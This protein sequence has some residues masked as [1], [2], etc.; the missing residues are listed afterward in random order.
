MLHAGE[1]AVVEAEAAEV[2]EIAGGAIEKTHDHALAV[3]GGDGGD[4]EVDFAAQDF[5]FDASVLR[6]TAFGDIELGHQ[7]EARDDGG[8]HFARRHVLVEEDAVD[9][10]A[11]AEFLLEG[12]DVDVAGALFDG[13]GDHGVDQADDR[14]FAGHVAQMLEVLAVFDGVADLA[15][16]LPVSP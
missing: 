10:E 13:G 11:D 3:K 15:C 6:E 1:H 4:T 2:V 9:A 12:L 7:L 8:L 5:D 16:C 14:R